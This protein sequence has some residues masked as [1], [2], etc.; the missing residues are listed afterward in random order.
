MQ[1]P[2]AQPAAVL[3]DCDTLMLDMDGTLLDLAFDTYMWQ[4]K[5]PLEYARSRGLPDELARAE[6]YEKYQSVLGTLD[7]YCLDHWSDMLGIDVLGLHREMHHRICFLPGAREFLV[8]A[9]RRDMRLLLVSNSHP[10]TL[11]LKTEVTG[12]AGFFDGIYLSHEVGYAK[13]DQAFWH[14]LAD[15]ESFDPAR[16]VFVDDT[17]RVLN[18]ARAYGLTRL[19]AVTRPDSTGPTRPCGDFPGIEGVAQL[20]AS[21]A[22]MG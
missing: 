19:L 6:I 15:S 9:S 2:S 11:E 17:E 3:H 8:A 16:A 12:L 20:L 21:A 10:A 5:I 1:I 14:A 7:W 18:A 4:E 22:D 13:E